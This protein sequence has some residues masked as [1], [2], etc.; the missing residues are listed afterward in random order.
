MPRTGHKKGIVFLSSMK[1]GKNGITS[2]TVRENYLQSRILYS[3]TL[4]QV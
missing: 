3:T 2:K 1:L 4:I